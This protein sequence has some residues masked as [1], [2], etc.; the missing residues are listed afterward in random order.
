MRSSPSLFR[1]RELSLSSAFSEDSLSPFEVGENPRPFSFRL[2]ASVFLCFVRWLLASRKFSVSFQR[3]ERIFILSFRFFFSLQ[4]E[5]FFSVFF[6]SS[7]NSLF[8][9]RGQRE[10]SF[11]LPRAVFGL[12]ELR[13]WVV[14]YNLCGP[15]SGDLHSLRCSGF[16]TVS[17]PSDQV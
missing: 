12:L 13:V 14:H 4:V 10:F 5:F 9:S 17:M 15:F 11:F 3:L 2:S 7:E 1:V 16:K 8:P 6:E